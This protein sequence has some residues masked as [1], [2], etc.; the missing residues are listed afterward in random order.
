VPPRAPLPLVF[1]HP[2][3]HT[4]RSP[5]THHP[6]S[7]CQQPPSACRPRCRRRARPPDHRR[8]GQP[9]SGKDS[10]LLTPKLGHPRHQF[11]PAGFP[12]SPRHRLAGI[13]RAP[14]PSAVGRSSSAS[15]SGLPAQAEPAHTPGRAGSRSRLSPSAQCTFSI[16]FRILLN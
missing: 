13:D 11:T 16:S 15:G 14:P 3:H 4:V 5:P 2:S 8:R 6:S 10:P 9:N 7:A 12:A 1:L